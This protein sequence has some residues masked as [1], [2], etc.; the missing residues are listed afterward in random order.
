MA[1]PQPIPDELWQRLARLDG[2]CDVSMVRRTEYQQPGAG[3]VPTWSSMPPQTAN[4]PQRRVWYVRVNLIRGEIHEMIHVTEQ[5]LAAALEAA[6]MNAEAR[7]WHRKK[8]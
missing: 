8:R 2:R 1:T 5:T 4:P 6:V 3:G 7:G